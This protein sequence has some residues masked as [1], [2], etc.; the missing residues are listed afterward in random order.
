MTMPEPDPAE[1][2]LGSTPEELRDQA[3]RRVKKR[4][5]FH[6][7]VFVYLIVNLLL[8]GLWL[9]TGAETGGAVPWPIF[10]TLG[11]GA[12]VLLN[13]WD[14]Y[15][16]RPISQAEVDREVNRLAHHG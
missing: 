14:V 7:H 3:L 1:E 12:A 15:V 8:W 9:V 13:A 4:R 11:W 16:R 2:L 5:D 10:P 6:T